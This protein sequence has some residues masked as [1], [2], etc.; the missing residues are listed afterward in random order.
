MSKH[1]NISI[2]PFTSIF[3]WTQQQ[4]TQRVPGLGPLSAQRSHE[5]Y[6]FSIRPLLLTNCM[7]HR[8]FFHSGSILGSQLALFKIN[9]HCGGTNWKLPFNLY[10]R[11]PVPVSITCQNC[12]ALDLAVTVAIWSRQRFNDLRPQ[13]ETDHIN[14]QESPADPWSYLSWI[15]I[16][17]FYRFSAVC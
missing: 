9:H 11:N 15:L 16:L 3:C 1:L 6:K 17:Y 8:N 10:Y 13:P 7:Q 2:L 14:I 4:S 12:S 5:W